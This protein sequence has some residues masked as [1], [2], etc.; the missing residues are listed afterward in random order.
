MVTRPLTSS[1]RPTEDHHASR[2]KRS[3]LAGRYRLVVVFSLLAFVSVG[4]NVAFIAELHTRIEKTETL[5]STDS[6]GNPTGAVNSELE[7]LKGQNTRMTVLLAVM[8]VCFG[9]IVYLFF[10]NVTVP[11]AGLTRATRRMSRGD[12]GATVQV[13]SENDFE[14]IAQTINDMAA[15][16]QEVLLLMGTTVGNLQSSVEEIERLIESD[17]AARYS[18]NFRKQVQAIKRDLELL[19]SVMREF[20]FYHTKFDGRKVVPTSPAS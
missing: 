12:L 11:L 8:V 18:E 3:S 6:G 17:N 9:S 14:E 5:V 4:L 20:E 15:N 13:H 7:S 10:R 19:S 2:G 1:Q 16:F